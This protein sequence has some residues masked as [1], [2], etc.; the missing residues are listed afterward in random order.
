MAATYKKTELEVSKIYLDNAN[1]RHDPIDNEPDI[2]A[3]LLAREQVRPLAKDIAEQGTTSPLDRFAVIPHPRVRGAYVSAEGNRRLCAVKL[4]NDPDK[5]PNDAHR[6]FFRELKGKLKRP[7]RSI[8]AVVFQSRKEANHWLA[9]RHEGPLGGVGTKGWD[10]RAKERFS[11]RGGRGENPNT[12][13]ALL[14]EY[15]LERDLISQEA[16]DAISLTTV[17]RFLRSPVFRNALGL[18]GIRDLTIIVPQAGVR[19]RRRALPE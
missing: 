16:H 11:R 12:Q 18:E 5:A 4:L 3:H 14:L 10:A 19:P 6:R 15:A 7:I 13:A 8:D 1:P 9:L 2:I 17:T